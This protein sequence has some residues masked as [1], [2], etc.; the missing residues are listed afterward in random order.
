MREL[1]SDGRASMTWFCAEKT[2]ARIWTRVPRSAGVKDPARAL[3]HSIKYQS[4]HMSIK[5]KKNSL[6][7]KHVSVPTERGR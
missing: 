2:A 7:K 6:Q 3:P 5:L 1:N 4:L